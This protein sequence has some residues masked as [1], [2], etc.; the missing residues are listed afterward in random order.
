MRPL[1][2]TNYGIAGGTLDA[3][4]LYADGIRR[5]LSAAE[6]ECHRCTLGAAA[7]TKD[8]RESASSN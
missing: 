6:L 7:T 5:L 1:I 2:T 4:E 8:K 3:T